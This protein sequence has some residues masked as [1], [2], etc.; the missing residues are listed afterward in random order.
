MP[1]SSAQTI[2]RLDS[3]SRLKMIT[4]F[5]G[6]VHNISTNNLKLRKTQTSNLEKCLLYW[7]P[8][9][10]QFLDFIYR[11]VLKLFFIVWQCKPRITKVRY[12]YYGLDK[13]YQKAGY[14]NLCSW[15]V[16][17][18]KQKILPVTVEVWSINHCSSSVPFVR[19][20]VRL[21]SYACFEHVHIFKFFNNIISA[22]KSPSI[23]NMVS[24]PMIPSGSFIQAPCTYCRVLWVI[25]LPTDLMLV[26]LSTRNR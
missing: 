19:Q 12:K 22:I 18:R 7:S 13:K 1:V 9:I 25:G 15:N 20:F 16:M 17:C 11:M 6:F 23:T 14:E 3:Q 4:I 2:S 10:S 21:T 26:Q 5:C 8:T 24:A